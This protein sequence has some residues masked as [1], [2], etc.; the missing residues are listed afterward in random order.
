[1]TVDFYGPPNH[2]ITAIHPQGEEI[3]NSPAHNGTDA[4]SRGRY[5]L[6][7]TAP[8]GRKR[9]S[10]LDRLSFSL[11]RGVGRLTCSAQLVQL[12]SDGE[13]P[14]DEERPPEEVAESHYGVEG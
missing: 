6:P 9:E 7:Q 13:E 1:M 8:L 2:S 12:P 14:D 4:L 5:R 10:L 3:A 11:R